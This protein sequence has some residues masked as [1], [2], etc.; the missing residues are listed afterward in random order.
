M[1]LTGKLWPSFLDVD[2]QGLLEDTG[3]VQG[4]HHSWLPVQILEA[5]RQRDEVD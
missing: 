4:H 5:D 2:Q 1:L 3:Q